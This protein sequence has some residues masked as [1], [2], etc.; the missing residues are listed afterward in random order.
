M[1][2]TIALEHSLHTQR[3]GQLGL[4]VVGNT[5]NHSMQ[6]RGY[7]NHSPKHAATLSRIDR[8]IHGPEAWFIQALHFMCIFG[9]GIDVRF[10]PPVQCLIVDIPLFFATLVYLGQISEAALFRCMV[11]ATDPTHRTQE[12]SLRPKAHAT[13]DRT[14][15]EGVG[16]FLCRVEQKN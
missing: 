7:S 1:L 4:T 15:S 6:G 11:H 8:W 12:D 2:I 16:C 5:A 13:P 9:R 14:L 3:L 10:L